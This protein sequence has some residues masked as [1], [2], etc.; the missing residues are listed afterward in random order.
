MIQNQCEHLFG[1][2]HIRSIG[3][4]FDADHH[5]TS[6]GSNHEFSMIRS[7][8][9]PMVISCRVE[10]TCSHSRLLPPLS[11]PYKGGELSMLFIYTALLYPH[12]C[13][14]NPRN[15]RG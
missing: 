7:Y 6:P 5:G 3:D 14:N 4:K 15:E 1:E 11:P 9:V 8:V 13:R 10:L 2:F 12:K